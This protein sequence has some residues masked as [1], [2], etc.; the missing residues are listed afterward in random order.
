MNYKWKHQYFENNSKEL[1]TNIFRSLEIEQYFQKTLKDNGFSLQNY[2]I[3]FLNSKINI[4]LTVCKL[5]QINL[6]TKELNLKNQ[7]KNK[8]LKRTQKHPQLKNLST[9]KK[10]LHALKISKTYRNKTNTLQASNLNSLTGKM[11]KSLKLFTKNKLNINLTIKEINFVNSNLEATRALETLFK[12]Q[13]TSFFQEGKKILIPF[14]TQNSAKL[15]GNF[16]ANQ[17]RIVKK[18][19]N[20]FLNFLQESLRIMITQKF[21]RIRGIKIVINGRLNNA[22]R[23]QNRVIKLGKISLISNISKIDYSESTAFTSNGTIGVKVWTSEK[24]NKC[25]YNRK[26]RNIKKQKKEKY[27]N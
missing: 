19:Q 18:Q 1:H 11:L 10:Y 24:T 15:I 6:K 21:S 14:V 5:K 26:K 9:K 20:F 16:I 27:V 4:L 12:F 7:K 25:F 2:Q 23:S 8:V 3:N 13:R 22:A 17:L